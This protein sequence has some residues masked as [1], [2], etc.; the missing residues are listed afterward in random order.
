[1]NTQVQEHQQQKDKSN[2]ISLLQ[3]VQEIYGYL[4]EKDLK[5]IAEYVG[6]PV[7]SVYEVAAIDKQFRLTQPGKNLIRVCRGAV[8][9]VKS[10]ASILSA[11]ETEL[12]IKAG[13]TTEDKNFTLEKVTCVGACSLAPVI[14][15]NDEFY[16]RVLIREIPKILNKY[17]ESEAVKMEVEQTSN[18]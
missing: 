4:P 18:A 17:K 2:L 8:C 6:I 15:I 5:A 10:S 14:N 12:G 9:H 13:Q 1:M 16:G 3:D 11:L 7:S